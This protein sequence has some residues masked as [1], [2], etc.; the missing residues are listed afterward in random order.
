M[1]SCAVNVTQRCVRR[2]HNRPDH[3]I[4]VALRQHQK[5][6]GLHKGNTAD[7][8]STSARKLILPRPIADDETKTAL[9]LRRHSHEIS[10]RNH[11]NM[12]LFSFKEES[13]RPKL[14]A[15][16]DISESSARWK[17]PLHRPVCRRWRCPIERAL[18]WRCFVR[19]PPTE[20]RS[21]RPP[22]IITLRSGSGAADSF[23]I[24]R[25]G[26]GATLALI[27]GRSRP[28]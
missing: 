2:R 11:L 17:P 22:E 27:Y 6:I 26:P 16:T 8:T 25:R 13:R 14:S 21:I 28:R 23:G 12:S 9:S 10:L 5:W 7:N 19:S 24:G 15:S 18:K 4:I 20:R 3:V 1:P